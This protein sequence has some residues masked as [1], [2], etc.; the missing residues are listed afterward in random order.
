MTVYQNK[1][2]MCTAL[3]SAATA[4]VY[5]L[6]VSCNTSMLHVLAPAAEVGS[7]IGAVSHWFL[8][9]RDAGAPQADDM[10]S[11]VQPHTSAVIPPT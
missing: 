3:V 1:H 8:K 9:L 4:D 10:L 2:S 6:M 11:D 7:S 5:T